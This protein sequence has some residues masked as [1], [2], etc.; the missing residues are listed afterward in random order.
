MREGRVPETF[1]D[2]VQ[3]AV[4]LA[5]KDQE[6][7]DQALTRVMASLES[8]QASLDDLRT[9]QYETVPFLLR[10]GRREA[11]VRIMSRCLSRGA[12]PSFAWLMLHPQ[13]ESVRADPR[14]RDL[15]QQSRTDFAKLLRV[16]DDAQRRGDLPPYLV[17]PL[18]ELRTTLKM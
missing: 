15:L 6:K 2:R 13:L 11:A 1:F 14:L 17:Q 10:D 8:D 3:L 16:L 9:T 7:S 4:A 5:Q 12:V 18:A